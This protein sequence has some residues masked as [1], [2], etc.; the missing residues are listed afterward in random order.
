LQ[1]PGG[2]AD[3]HKKTLEKSLK[4]APPYQS[5]DG[6]KSDIKKLASN[7]IVQNG[8]EEDGIYR[9]VDIMC[10]AGVFN[11]ASTCVF[12]IVV[13]TSVFNIVLLQMCQAIE[14]F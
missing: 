5:C 4:S 7:G 11:M 2:D 12:N 1:G 6:S 13:S 3:E 8:L 14:T 10:S 9:C